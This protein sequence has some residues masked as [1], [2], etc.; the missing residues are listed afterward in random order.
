M[1]VRLC[2]VQRR[3]V[4]FFGEDIAFHIVFV[5]RLAGKDDVDSMAGFVFFKN[6]FPFFVGPFVQEV[7]HF[8]EFLARECV[9]DRDAF[10]H[11]D[12][13]SFSISAE[14]F[15]AVPIAGAFGLP[16]GAIVIHQLK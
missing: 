4:L 12:F 16:S 7:V 5:D 10:E 2:V 14:E 9:K 13:M 8:K 1:S 15:H 6:D 11:L 3:T